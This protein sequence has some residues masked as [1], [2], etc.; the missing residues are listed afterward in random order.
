MQGERLP[1]PPRGELPG[2]DMARFTGLDAFEELM[3]DCWAEHPASR[4]SFEC[5][6]QRLHRQLQ[7]HMSAQQGAGRCAS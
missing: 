6:A 2:V 1:V 7:L 4:P 5:I 3:Y